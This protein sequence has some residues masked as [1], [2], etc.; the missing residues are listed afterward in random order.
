M[1]VKID[2]YDLSQPGRERRKCVFSC[3]RRPGEICEVLL[4]PWPI[5]DG[6]AW[7]WDGNREQPTLT[8]SI[9]CN[10][11]SGC[12]WHGFITAGKLIN[13]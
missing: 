8:P 11:P 13:A 10:G 5:S 6:K 1:S 3:P 4:K 2:D 7:T 9:N 12:G